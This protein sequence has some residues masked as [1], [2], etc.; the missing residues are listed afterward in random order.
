VAAQ[1]L[2]V[3]PLQ[4]PDALLQLRLLQ[5]QLRALTAEW[6]RQ[7]A[8]TMPPMQQRPSPTAG[9]WLL[10]LLPSHHKLLLLLLLMLVQLLLLLPPRLVLLLLLQAL[11]LCQYVDK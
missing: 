8:S 5:L 10:L 4:L 11:H 7:S 6:H 2:A 3:L 1:V 9:R